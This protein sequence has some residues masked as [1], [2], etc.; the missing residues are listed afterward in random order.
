MIIF[1]C[2]G[3]IVRSG[4]NVALVVQ[5][6]FLFFLLNHNPVVKTADLVILDFPNKD[7][8]KS[9]RIFLTVTTGV[10]L[11]PD[12]VHDLHKAIRIGRDLA[13]L[14]SVAIFVAKLHGGGPHNGKK[15]FANFT[16]FRG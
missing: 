6:S 12:A 5:V 11:E 8:L 4:L 13:G 15:K 7:V 16:S 1:V 2:R 9:S 10:Q 14:L 3:V